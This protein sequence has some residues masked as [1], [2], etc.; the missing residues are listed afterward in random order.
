[1]IDRSLTLHLALLCSQ[2]YRR[3][4]ACR[5]YELCETVEHGT[6]DAT[7]FWRPGR[8][9][10]AVR[11]TELVDGRGPIG[12]FREWLY[13]LA[14]R[15]VRWGLYDVHVHRGFLANFKG[16]WD[17]VMNTR[18]YEQ[19]IMSNDQVIYTGHSRGGAIAQLAAL[20][21]SPALVTTFGAPRVGG[22]SFV[23]RCREQGLRHR[24]IVNAL[25]VVPR[26]P[27]PLW[28]RH[29]GDAYRASWTGT[30]RIDD[31]VEALT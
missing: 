15:P 6:D 30:H 17:R 16:L 26:L 3:D 8:L 28:Y 22:R 25:D 1:M 10:V 4:P 11:G 2:S 12:R 31:Y 5:A 27:P 14:F 29:Y 18:P 24:R 7:V 20:Y 21:E 13:N 19:H 23:E 9:V